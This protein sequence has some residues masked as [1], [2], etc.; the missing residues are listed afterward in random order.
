MQSHVTFCRGRV[1]NTE[2]ES[3]GR[4]E[5]SSRLAVTGNTARADVDVACAVRSDRIGTRRW[6]RASILERVVL[7]E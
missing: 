3:H 5:H 2:A 7:A 1:S 6:F 4:M